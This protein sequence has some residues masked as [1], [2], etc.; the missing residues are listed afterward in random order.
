M[1]S[2]FN[3]PVKQSK[4]VTFTWGQACAAHGLQVCSKTDPDYLKVKMTYATENQKI[5]DGKAPMKIKDLKEIVPAVKKNELWKE[6]CKELGIAIALK[7]TEEYHR[8]SEL[9]K[10]KVNAYMNTLQ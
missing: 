9:Y 10:E 2:A 5:Q 7:D 8:V 6:C 3:T 1:A 4:P